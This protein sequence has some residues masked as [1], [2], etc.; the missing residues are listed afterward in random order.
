MPRNQRWQGVRIVALSC[1]MPGVSGL[2]DVGEYLRDGPV[3]RGG[4]GFADLDGFVESLG[5]RLVLDEGTS[6]S[7]ANSLILSAKNPTPL[8]TTCGASMDSIL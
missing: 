7:C 2:V 3:E 1:L 8:A 6:C 5:E 4:D